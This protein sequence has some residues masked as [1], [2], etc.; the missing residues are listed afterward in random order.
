LVPIGVKSPHQKF[1]YFSLF[2]REQIFTDPRTHFGHKYSYNKIGPIMKSLA[3]TLRALE[4][5]LAII[6]AGDPFAE[7]KQWEDRVHAGFDRLRTNPKFMQEVDPYTMSSRGMSKSAAQYNHQNRVKQAE[8][9]RRYGIDT[10]P[11]PAQS[12]YGV[13]FK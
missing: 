5:R 10:G 7:Y 6:E 3:E 1:K 11:A 8:I 9:M 4:Q 12:P 13:D 2:F